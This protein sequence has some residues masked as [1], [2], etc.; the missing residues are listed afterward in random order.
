MKGVNQVHNVSHSQPRGLIIP[1]TIV[2]PRGA[3]SLG[4]ATRTGV[5]CHCR[6]DVTMIT[7]PQVSFLLSH[8]AGRMSGCAHVRTV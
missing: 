2:R 1:C 7:N 4:C 3:E 8:D 5:H 6:R